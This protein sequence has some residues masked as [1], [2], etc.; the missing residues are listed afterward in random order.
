MVHKYNGM[1]LSHKKKEIMPLAA[2]Q[3]DLEIITK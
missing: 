3:M 1:L 2:T